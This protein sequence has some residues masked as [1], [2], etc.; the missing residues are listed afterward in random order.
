L[1]RAKDFPA[2]VARITTESPLWDWFEV[3]RWMYRRRT[4][5]LSVVVEAKM[6]KEANLALLQ[7]EGFEGFF[8]R[9][10]RAELTA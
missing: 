1:E 10:F 9:K 3:A 7:P 6:V 8:A 4:L 5:S 2:P